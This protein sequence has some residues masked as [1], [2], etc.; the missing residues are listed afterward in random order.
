[1][2]SPSFLGRRAREWMTLLEVVVG[3]HVTCPGDAI[4]AG[5][6]VGDVILANIGSGTNRW[7][8]CLFEMRKG[9]IQTAIT[10]QKGL[11]SGSQGR[12]MLPSS[13]DR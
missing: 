1:M 4:C 8:S 10:P 3:P 13:R 6:I 5:L 12:H 2:V 7:P 11:C 9:R